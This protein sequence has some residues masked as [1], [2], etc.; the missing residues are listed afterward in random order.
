MIA[1]VGTIIQMKCTDTYVK[2]FI[3]VVNGNTLIATNMLASLSLE[4]R[5]V[6]RKWVIHNE[7]T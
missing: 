4:Q 5:I 7:F 6:G 1:V 2:S 3:R